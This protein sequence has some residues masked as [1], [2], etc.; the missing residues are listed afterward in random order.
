MTHSHAHAK[1]HACARARAAILAEQLSGRC[2][3][4]V[5][6]L[7]VSIR[8]NNASVHRKRSPCCWDGW[9]G[10]RTTLAWT[11]PHS[12]RPATPSIGPPAVQAAC[13]QDG[14]TPRTQPPTKT[15]FC[16]SHTT[17]FSSFTGNGTFCCPG[18]DPV[19]NCER[20]QSSHPPQDCR[21]ACSPVCQQTPRPRP[22]PRPA[23]LLSSVHV[24]PIILLTDEEKNDK[25]NKTRQSGMAVPAFQ[26]SRR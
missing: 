1:P 13:G 25:K 6:L 5:V 15:S 10:R 8:D 23:R 9:E 20:R 12:Y 2:S 14:W 21:C 24:V 16:P 3:V 26:L 17:W 18:L 11:E 4:T 22:R 19:L 7:L